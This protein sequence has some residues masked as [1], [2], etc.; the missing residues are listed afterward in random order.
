MPEICTKMLKKLSEKL[1]AKFPAT[2][3]SYSMVKI[4]CLDDNFSEFFN[5][6]ASPIEAQSIQQKEKNRRKRIGQKKLIEETQNFY[7]CIPKPK[8]CKT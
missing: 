4:A 2:T 8:C 7:S 5:L 6:E 1:R 3:H